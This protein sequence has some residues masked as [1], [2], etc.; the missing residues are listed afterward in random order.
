MLRKKLFVLKHLFMHI[1]VFKAEGYA[2]PALEMAL[3]ENITVYDALFIALAKKIGGK[4]YTSDSQQCKVAS[5][6]VNVT[7][8]K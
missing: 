3:K 4:L 7:F 8:I 6:Y 1:K 2:A 5:N